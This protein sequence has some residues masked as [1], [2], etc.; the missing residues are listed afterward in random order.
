M[1]TLYNIM[2]IRIASKMDIQNT[3]TCRPLKTRRQ[4]GIFR[5]AVSQLLAPG[6]TISSSYPTGW[7]PRPNWHQRGF[8]TQ[9]NTHMTFHC[10]WAERERE[11]L[12]S[13]LTLS[14][15]I[16]QSFLRRGPFWPNSNTD[17]WIDGDSAAP[18]TST[19]ACACLCSTFRSKFLLSS[20][21]YTLI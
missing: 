11:D 6:S 13:Q 17:R 20:I 9:A 4:K 14:R 12:S 16:T 1:C 15:I 21:T 10:P 18:S 8:T 2:F 7:A 3:K 5:E 19:R